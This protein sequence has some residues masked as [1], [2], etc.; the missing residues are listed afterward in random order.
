MSGPV[1]V[2]T[3]QA[4]AKK[5]SL[6]VVIP[7]FNEERRLGATLDKVLAYCVGRYAPLEVI[8][9]DDGSTDAT[10]QVAEER[11]A[12]G[13]PVRV[14]A[15]AS[16]RGKGFSVRRGVLEAQGELVLMTDADLSTPIEEIEKLSAALASSPLAVGS[17]GLPASRIEVSQ[18][19][20]RVMMGKTFNA[21]L[22]AVIGT[23]LRD[24][25]CGFKLFTREVARDLFSRATLEGFAFDAEVIFLAERLGYPVAEVPVRWINSPASTVHPLRDSARMFRDVIRLRWRH[26]HLAARSPAGGAPPSS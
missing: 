14:L 4:P 6:T 1:L 9:V 5:P 17:R 16:N 10:R 19:A 23:R 22:R 2:P 7:A 15:N 26:R 12:R 21:I 11:A 18:P 3:E 25:Q 24:T 13:A 20:Y 8:V